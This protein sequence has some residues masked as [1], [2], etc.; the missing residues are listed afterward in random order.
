MAHSYT[1]MTDIATYIW[2]MFNYISVITYVYLVLHFNESQKEL[3]CDD[4][5]YHNNFLYYLL[6]SEQLNSQI[7]VRQTNV[8]IELWLFCEV[9][10]NFNSWIPPFFMNV[11]FQWYLLDN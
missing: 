11:Q 3:V 7:Y 10:F 9:F 1:S 5:R 6:C 2:N 4:C 8:L